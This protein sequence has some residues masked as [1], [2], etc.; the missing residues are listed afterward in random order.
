VAY[1]PCDPD[2]AD[3]GFGRGRQPLINVSWHDAERYAAWLSEVTGTPY[4]LLS[5]AEYEFAARAGTRT[6]YPWGDEIGTNNANCGDCGSRWDDLAAGPGRLFCPEPVWS[7]RHGWQC[8]G[9][10]RGL[11][12]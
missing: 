6:A 11:L 4:R 3:S 12:S 9:V 8:L 5:E 2:I 10:G 7:L 1:G